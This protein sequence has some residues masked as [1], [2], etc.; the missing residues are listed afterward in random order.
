L[1]VT[2]RGELT[3]LRP[4]DALRYRGE[5]FVVERRMQFQEGD[6]SWI[7]Q[8]LSS[9]GSGRSLWLEIP[10]DPDK[11]LVAY[12]RTTPLDEVPNGGPEIEWRGE[13]MTLVASGRAAYRSLERSAAAKSGEIV[14]HDYAAG[15]RRVSF[16]C[17]TDQA[18][19]EVSEGRTVDAAEIELPF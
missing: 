13:R 2:G 1:R 4:A 7:E 18:T 8:R 6:A 10:A 15:D 11:P 16:E 9:D 19:W 17:R 3:A 14:Y 5:E 12:E